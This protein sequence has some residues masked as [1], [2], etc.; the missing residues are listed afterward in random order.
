[1]ETVQQVIENIDEPLIWIQ[2]GPVFLLG[3]AV[4]FLFGLA[5]GLMRLAGPLA[6][7]VMLAMVVTH[8]Y[9]YDGSVFSLHQ[10]QRCM[11]LMLMVAWGEMVGTDLSS[12]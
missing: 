10:M 8:L 11:L 4:Y 5:L 3:D 2:S 12:L 6:T 7:M 9:I 1:M